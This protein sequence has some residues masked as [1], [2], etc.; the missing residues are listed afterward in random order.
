V[1]LAYRD[2]AESVN[3]LASIKLKQ[4]EIL[5]AEGPGDCNEEGNEILEN[6]CNRNIVSEREMLPGE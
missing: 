2:G 6:D 3:R 4:V 5:A 1:R